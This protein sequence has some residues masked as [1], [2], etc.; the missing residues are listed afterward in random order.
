LINL[1]ISVEGNASEDVVAYVE[2]L[3]WSYGNFKIVKQTSQLGVDAHNLACMRMAEEIG[4]VLILEDDLVV[5]SHFQAYLDA[6]LPNYEETPEVFGV[7]LYRY[8]INEKNHFPFQLLPNNEFAYYQQRSSS[9]GTFYTWNKLEP[10][11]NFMASFDGDYSK[12]HL[13]QNVL[14]WSDEVFEKAVYIFLQASNSYMLFPRESFSTD[15]ADIGVH[16]KKQTNKYV[17]QSPLYLS[18]QIGSIPSLNT[19]E[20]KYDAFYELSPETVVKYNPALKAYP[21][22]MDCYGNKDKS[23]VRTEYLLSS[24]KCDN[25]VLGWERRLKPEVNNILLNN[26]G[27]H[28]SLGKVN[29]FSSERS[30]PDLKEDFL[31]YYPDTKFTDLVKMKWEEIKSRYR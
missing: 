7:S 30:I 18:S 20:N 12:F 16:M 14:K 9:K 29:C 2:G 5:S 13:P 28:Y 25:P 1:V 21:F 10:F 23:M 15:F 31:Y 22:E 11:F 24:K 6:A 3:T 17:H 8:S 19:A 26:Q 4:N 27:E